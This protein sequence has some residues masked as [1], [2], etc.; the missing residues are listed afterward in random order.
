MPGKMTE[1]SDGKRRFNPQ[2]AVEFY[3]ENG[4]A[5]GVRQADNKPRMSCVPYLFDIAKG[6]ISNQCSVRIFGVNPNIATSKETIWCR[7]GLYIWPSEATIMKVSSDD[8]NDTLAGTGA[9]TLAIYGLDTNYVEINE[10]V[11]LNG[12]TVVN[13]VNSYLRILYIEIVTAGSTGSNIGKVFVGAGI[14]TDGVPATVYSCMCEGLN[15]SMIGV[16]TVSANHTFYMV[17][18]VVSTD[19]NKGLDIELFIRP[20]GSVFQINYR[21]YLY[22]NSLPIPFRIPILVTEKSDIEVRAVAKQSGEGCGASF[23]GWCKEN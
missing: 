4:N 15:K 5:Y 12:Q 20:F 14:V 2:N 17:D 23:S 7:D 18:F 3:D 22:G 13:T 19:A 9:R 1:G 21:M 6:N 8:T 10:T 16:W 11:S